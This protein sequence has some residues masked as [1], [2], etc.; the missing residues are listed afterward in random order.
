MTELIRLPKMQRDAEIRAASYDEQDNTIEVV[1][2]TGST[3]RRVSWMEGEF[4]EELVVSDKAVRLDRLNAGAPFLDTHDRYSLDAVI[5]SVVAGTAK[6]AKGVGTARIQLSKAAGTL[7][8][9]AKIIEGTVRNVS[10]AYR[11]HGVEK[12][13]REGMVPLHRVIDWEPMEISAVPVG[14]DPGAQVRSGSDDELF[15]CRVDLC[16]AHLNSVRRL[17]MEMQQ[18]HFEVVR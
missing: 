5:G 9:V 11:I 7:D 10:V 16:S 8:R 14:F 12:T 6:I 3:G 4:D 13:Q 15:S 1:W 18:R 2:T 17:R